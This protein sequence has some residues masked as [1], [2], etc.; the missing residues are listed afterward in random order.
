MRFEALAFIVLII[1]LAADV[2]VVVVCA[3]GKEGE[4]KGPKEQTADLTTGLGDK[5]SIGGSTAGESGSPEPSAPSMTPP[6]ADFDDRSLLDMFGEASKEYLTNNFFP[7]TSE[8]C[9]W[10]WRHGRCEPAC[11]CRLR[12][13]FGDFHLGRSCRRRGEGGGREEEPSSNSDDDEFYAYDEDDVPPEDCD[14][15][16]DNLYFKAIDAL[17]KAGA[18]GGRW[19]RKRARKLTPKLKGAV[20]ERASGRELN[21]PLRGVK[22]F[23]LPEFGFCNGGKVERAEGGG[24][25]EEIE[26]DVGVVD[27]KTDEQELRPREKMV[28]E[29]EGGKDEG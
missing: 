16:P 18:K 27:V 21:L 12:Y 17:I 20:C 4:D 14:L 8:G 23:H 5:A 13:E 24:E 26:V 2:T 3:Q 7:P 28:V 15:A 1:C 6:P 10:N 22:S 11:E 9:D 29:N 19:G 25:E